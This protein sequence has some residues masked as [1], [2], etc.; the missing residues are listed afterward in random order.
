MRLP[1][2]YV[3]ESPM[4]VRLTMDDTLLIVLKN[5]NYLLII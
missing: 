5:K 2:M 1:L 3:M 4:G